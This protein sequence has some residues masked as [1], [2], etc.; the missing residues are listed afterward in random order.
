L[1]EVAHQGSISGAAAAL[2]YTPSAVSQQLAQLERQVGVRLVDRRSTGIVL[3]R[4]G[5]VMLAHANALLARASR[6]E[7][8]L[9]QLAEG[10]WGRLRVGAFSS[11]AAALMPEAIVAMRG[12]QPTCAVELVEQDTPESV[13]ELRRGELDLAIIVLNGHSPAEDDE[14]EITPLL[15]DRIDVL[16]PAKHR[17]SKAESV[18]LDDLRGDAWI[19]C[20]GSPVRFWM[21]ARGIEPNVIFNSDQHYVVHALVA[22]QVAVAFSPRLTQPVLEDGLLVKPIA[23]DPPIRR[24]AIAVRAE[25]RN[26][27]AIASLTDILFRVALSRNGS[28]VVERAAA[29]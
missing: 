14:L 6:A 20:S 9:R 15:D 13:S 1:R 16:L 11:A 23:P 24:V 2:N 4:A 21:T 5:Q 12:A 3:T 22:A 26:A 25:N 18:S 8:E 17:L 28:G 19:D 7:E 27:Q 29:P 10:N